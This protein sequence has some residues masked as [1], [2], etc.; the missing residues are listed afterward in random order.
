[1]KTYRNHRCERNHRSNQTFLNCAFPKAA[2]ITG[3]GDYAL[4]AWCRVTTITLWTTLEDAEKQKAWIDEL[5]CGGRC[6]RRHEII[7]IARG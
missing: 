5:A 6:T 2:W 1:M 7:R 3:Q 4:I